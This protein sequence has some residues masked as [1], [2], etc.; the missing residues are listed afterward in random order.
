MGVGTLSA[1]VPPRQ[2]DVT[3]SAPLVSAIVSTYRSERFLRGCLEDLEA[4]TIAASLEII[5]VDSASPEREQEI[6]QEFQATHTNIRYVRTPSRVTL[7]EA[8]NI[9]ISMARG[10]Y[11]TSANTDD[12]HRRD[13]FEVITNE[14]QRHPDAALAYADSLVTLRENAVWAD[15]PPVM[16]QRW[17]EFDRHELFRVC[18]IGAQ[19]VWRRDLHERYGSFDPSLVSAGDYEYW[20]RICA[21]ERF[22]H[23]AEPLGLYLASPGSI[24]HRNP[25]L[26]WRETE[27]ARARHWR[28]EWGRRPRARGVYLRPDLRYVARQL[29]RGRLQPLRDLFSHAWMLAHARI[30][31]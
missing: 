20:L 28:A 23:I 9:G 14:L 11:V 25:G 24:E 5:V 18:Y 12:R 6:V 8:W 1:A 7:Y 29:A 31:R 2:S 16:Y 26:G 3:N 19:P 13:F 17:P 10:T 4:Q 22:I 15:T 27:E 21:T 30:H